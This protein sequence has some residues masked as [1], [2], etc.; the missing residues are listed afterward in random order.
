MCGHV[1]THF[2]FP[3]IISHRDGETQETWGSMLKT[4]Y[5]DR[6]HIWQ[7]GEVTNEE[8]PVGVKNSIRELELIT[9]KEWRIVTQRAAEGY[10]KFKSRRHEI[11]NQTGEKEGWERRKGQW[12]RTAVFKVWSG[13]HG[14]LRP[15]P[16][17]WEE[18]TIFIVTWKKIC[19]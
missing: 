6:L 9:S 8:N 3:A 17:V 15:L 18:K 1:H 10:V 2:F 4:D 7:K 14:Y 19:L 16:E 12:S 13:K 11:Q 5:K